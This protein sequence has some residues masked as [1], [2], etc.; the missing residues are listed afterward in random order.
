MEALGVPP[1]GPEYVGNAG[2]RK[3][4]VPSTKKAAYKRI[5]I[6]HRAVS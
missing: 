6:R 1:L 3:V 4:G 5:F 2:R